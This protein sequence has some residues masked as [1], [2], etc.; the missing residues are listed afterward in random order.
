MLLLSLSTMTDATAC[1]GKTSYALVWETL[2]QQQWLGAGCY[3]QVAT[4]NR[5][6]RSLYARYDESTTVHPPRLYGR[7]RCPEK[8]TRGLSCACDAS[9]VSTCVSRLC[10]IK[11]VK[12]L[13][14]ASANGL[15]L[16][17]RHYSRSCEEAIRSGNVAALE[18]LLEHDTCVRNLA[19]MAC[20]EAARRGRVSPTVRRA[21]KK[22]VSSGSLLRA[23]HLLR[24]YGVSDDEDGYGKDSELGT[25]YHFLSRLHTASD[26]AAREEHTGVLLLLRS[27][28]PNLSAGRKH[29]S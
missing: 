6:S 15:K 20:H 18:W 16:S 26:A 5:Q 7:R 10:S 24:T 2:L 27:H 29:T 9:A 22:V 28:L 21:Y 25:L 19:A 14:W 4:V 17:Y 12:L 13:G 8:H 23:V 11:S 1:S 3:L